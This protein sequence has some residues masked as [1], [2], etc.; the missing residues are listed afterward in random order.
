[1]PRIIEKPHNSND[2]KN[3]ICIDESLDRS[4]IVNITIDPKPSLKII[5]LVEPNMDDQMSDSGIPM[6]D[7]SAKRPEMCGY[8]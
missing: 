7:K 3:D 8:K 4:C 1:M 2:R 5:N 6:V